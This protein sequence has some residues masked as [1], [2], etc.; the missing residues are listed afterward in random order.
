MS[1][2]L[3]VE[4]ACSLL[5]QEESQREILKIRNLEIESITLFSKTGNAKGCSQGGNKGH[6]KEKCWLVI[7]YAQWHPKAKKFP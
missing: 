2:L 6:V 1:P 5:Q 3:S 7:G 4:A